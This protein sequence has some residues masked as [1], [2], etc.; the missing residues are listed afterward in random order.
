MNKDD[1]YPPTTTSATSSPPR[2]APV[3]VKRETSADGGLFGKSKYKVWV[4][5]AILLL[6][7][8]SMFTGS[9][10]LRWSAGNLTRLSNDLFDSPLYDDLDILEVEE[11]EKLVRRMWDA[12]THSSR[13][14]PR[15]W[16]DAFQAA[17]DSLASEDPAVRDAAV[18]EIAKL[19]LS[20][21]FISSDPVLPAHSLGEGTKE[22]I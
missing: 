11:R 14:L 3:P 16:L 6:A 13:L 21:L 8:W 22:F 10:T 19:S 20:S 15:F 5:A 12:Y 4:L 2:P 18:Q 9:V 7:F 17:Y 1:Y